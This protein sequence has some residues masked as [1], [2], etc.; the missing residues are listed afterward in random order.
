[1]A[2]IKD[3]FSEIEPGTDDADVEIDLDKVLSSVTDILN[4]RPPT[5]DS[6]PS[7]E[8]ATEPEAETA[9][10]PEVESDELGGE[11]D[12][13]VGGEDAEAEEDEETPPSPETSPPPAAA[14]DPLMDL[15]PERRAALLA[16]D[17][18]VMA[19]PD[20]RAKVFGILSGDSDAPSVQAAPSLPEHIDPDSFEASLWRDNQDLKAQVAQIGQATRVQAEATAQERARAAASTAAA[21]FGS[22]YADRLSEADIVEIAQYAGQ[23]GLAGAFMSTAEAK[24]D[25]VVGYTQALEHVLWTN[26][27]FRGRVLGTTGGPA[28]PPGDQPEAQTRK[29]KLTALSG[30]ASPVSGPAPQRPPL[31]H[32]VDGKLSEKSRQTIVKDFATQLRQANEG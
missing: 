17:Q 7:R 30:A 20:K 9:P 26:E 8:A 27:A 1:M 10:R 31:E 16:L 32:G 23:T 13:T 18:T 3:L 2:N 4:D 5:P 11:V 22:K 25:P 12:V 15:P 24:N 21:N 19:D 6:P 29:R 14:H 28:T